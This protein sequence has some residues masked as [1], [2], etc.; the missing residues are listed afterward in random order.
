MAIVYTTNKYWIFHS[1]VGISEHSTYYNGM[2]QTV[3]SN[4]DTLTDT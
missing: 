4:F 3:Q 2:V 1:M